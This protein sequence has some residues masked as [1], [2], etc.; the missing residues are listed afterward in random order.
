MMKEIKIAPYP[1]GHCHGC[2][3]SSLLSASYL[4]HLYL[5]LTTRTGFILTGEEPSNLLQVFCK[6]GN[7]YSW[8]SGFRVLRLREGLNQLSHSYLLIVGKNYVWST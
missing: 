2:L 5:P 4:L 6:S 1:C 8:S 3:K 7:R